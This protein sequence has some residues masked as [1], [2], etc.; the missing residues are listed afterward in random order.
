MTNWKKFKFVLSVEFKKLNRLFLLGVIAA[1][2]EIVTIAVIYSLLTVMSDP[3]KIGNIPIYSDLVKFVSPDNSQSIIV[4]YI[5]IILLIIACSLCRTFVVWKTN[6]TIA[7]VRN[8]LCVRLLSSYLQRDYLFHLSNNSSELSKNVLSEIDLFIVHYFTPIA[9]LIVNVLIFVSITLSICFIDWKLTAITIIFFLMVYLLIF[10]VV[11]TRLKWLGEQKVL[12]NRNRYTVVSE[13]FGGIRNIKLHN[14]QSEFVRRFKA[15]SRDFSQIT[16]GIQTLSQ[17]PR[18]I[19]E[20]FVVILLASLTLTQFYLAESQSLELFFPK[21]GVFGFAALK[22]LPTLQLIYHSASLIRSSSKSLDILCDGLNTQTDAT[23]RLHSEATITFEDKLE[24]INVSFT[25]PGQDEP[26][27]RDL[28]IEIRCGESVAIV[29]RSGSGKSTFADLL[30]GLLNATDGLIKV[31][32]RI[33][34]FSNLNEWKKIIGYVPQDIFVSD[35]DIYSN[36]AFAQHPNSID[37]ARVKKCCM[38]AQIDELL[39]NASNSQTVRKTLGEKGSRL[40][41]GQKQ[42]LGI[43]RALYSQ[44]KFIVFD[45]AT[46]ALDNYTERRVVEA[47][48]RLKPDITSVIV[49]HGLNTVIQADKII[50]MKNGC[51]CC[52]GSYEY[53]EANCDEFRKLNQMNETETETL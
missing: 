44:P 51:V 24:L 18:F 33:L 37:Y 36:V 35:A 23:L 48:D 41:G 45:E 11:R 47:V 27:V 2:S 42:R 29:G 6:F 30:M 14:T 38:I 52:S 10:M 9:Q 53:L 4:F 25:F 40:S 46:S 19:V 26:S 15:P 43:A 21:I 31:D 8:S 7:F 34:D 17:V 1:S 50:V 3:S 12:A 16:A 5:A 28:N 32:G 39:D 49:A 22:I 13:A 20:G